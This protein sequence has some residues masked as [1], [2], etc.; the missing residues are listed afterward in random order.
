MMHARLLTLFVAAT[1]AAGCTMSSSESP[2]TPTAIPLTASATPASSPSVPTVPPV[3]PTVTLEPPRTPFM[4]FTAA[5]SVENALLRENPGYLFPQLA[6]LKQGSALLVMGRSPGGEW[7]LCQ[8]AD[9][10]AGWVFAQLVDASSEDLQ[11]APVIWPASAQVVVGLVRDQA[12]VPVSGIQ[13]SIIQGTGN[14]APRNDAVTDGS[15]QFYAF[16][17][18]EAAGEW[19][20]SYTAVSCTSNTMDSSCNCIGGTCGMPD[21]LATTIQFPRPPQDVLQF[22]WR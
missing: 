13:F 11:Q 2:S 4:A 12:G 19:N 20:V 7:L 8:T 5:T 10:R 22:T 17:P 18:A 16:M 14:T 21:P 15:G 3:A 9:H 1:L 6:A